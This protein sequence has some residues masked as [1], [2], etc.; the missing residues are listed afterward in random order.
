MK[1]AP[2]FVRFVLQQTGGTLVNDR[3]EHKLI[4]LSQGHPVDTA[5]FETF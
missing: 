2:A 1:I 4:M 5:Q 3:L